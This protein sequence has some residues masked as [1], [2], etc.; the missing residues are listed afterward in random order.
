MTKRELREVQK[1]IDDVKKRI[2]KKYETGDDTDDSV[3]IG[4]EIVIDEL[5]TLL[6]MIRGELK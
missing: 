2:S 3:A 6:K 1:F 4:M 5:E